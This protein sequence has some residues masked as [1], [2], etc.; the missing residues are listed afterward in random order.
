MASF[1]QK[2]EAKGGFQERSKGIISFKDFKGMNVQA[3]RQ[4]LK[5]EEF[6]WLE[7]A[8]PI[9]NGNLQICPSVS[10]NLTQNV[11]IPTN[12]T[13]A[14]SLAANINGTNYIIG[15]FSDGSAYAVTIPVNINVS[16]TIPLT[17][18]NFAAAGTFS[19]SG[20]AAIQWKNERICIIDPAKGYFTWDGVV[21]VPNGGV[22]S[23][24]ITNGGTGYS[25]SFAVTFTGGGGTGAT[26]T[27][28][29]KSGVIISVQI[30]NPGSGYTSAP[31]AVFTAGG[32]SSGAG[33]GNVLAGPAA[34]QAIASY[35]GHMWVSNN[36]TISISDTGS[37]FNFA[38]GVATSVTIVDSTLLSNITALT[39]A[40]NFLY[41]FGNDSVDVIG[42]V[43]VISGALSFTRTNLTA[44]VGT[45][46]P[47]SIFP[48]FKSVMFAGGTGFYGMLGASPQ[49]LSDVLNPLYNLI[50][51]TQPISGGQVSIYNI[52][53]SC[54]SFSFVDSISPGN[55]GVERNI[56]ALYF[57]Q[58][59]WLSSQFA[60]ITLVTG[61]ANGNA[62]Q[63]FGWASNVLY[64]LFAQSGIPIAA[65]IQTALSDDEKTE[66]DKDSLKLA[67]G[68]NYSS[69]SS[70]TISVNVD[71]EYRSVAV[72]NSPSNAIEFINNSGQDVIFTGTAGIPISFI[73]AGYN[74]SVVD[75]E[76]S[77]GKYLGMTI[78]SNSPQY[79]INRLSLAYIEGA[80]F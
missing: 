4:A 41:I 57:D 70:N 54:F 15:F 29:A 55:T 26:G 72:L 42:D 14:T 10:V 19:A 76:V 61:L 64:L 32:G 65:T 38:T 60:G 78:T 36:R 39:V 31:T 5:K 68:I 56:L 20:V 66:V 62:Y 6:S 58:K 25:N 28:T 1:G 67:A 37:F 40:N 51:F 43:Q 45:Q 80:S 52:L 53:C 8:I 59:W 3:A 44:S 13:V 33:T 2:R 23:V 69:A 7:N 34:G 35:S 9:G 27:A 49:K 75:A 77:G 79:T 47:L 22:A 73:G 16:V 24:T 11:Q 30:T 74:Y 17:V 71:N 21:L 63:L 48:Y 18:T 12:I 50:D 46:I